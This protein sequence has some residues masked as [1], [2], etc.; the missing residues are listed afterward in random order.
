[1]SRRGAR[2]GWMA[3]A[4]LVLGAAPTRAQLRTGD[5]LAVV[6]TIRKY[7]AALAVGDTATVKGL[8]APGALLFSRGGRAALDTAMIAAEIRWAGAVERSQESPV[9]VRVMGWAAYAYQGAM[10]RARG[11]PDLISGRQIYLYVLSRLGESWFI[12]A[13]HSSTGQL[14]D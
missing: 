6:A 13:I 1:M 2:A 10:I 4:G 14:P 8:L 7:N 9:H 11:A 3:F 5:S 12:E